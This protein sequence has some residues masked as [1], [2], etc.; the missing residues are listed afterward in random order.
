MAVETDEIGLTN[1]GLD[2]DSIP[3]HHQNLTTYQF[4]ITFSELSLKNFF[5]FYGRGGS[6]I[7]LCNI[8]N[9]KEIKKEMSLQ[10]FWKI[11]SG[12]TCWDRLQSPRPGNP[13][14]INTKRLMER[15]EK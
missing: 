6:S 11:K 4:G 7:F 10:C 1:K 2:K 8:E 5:F 14:R 13:N 12:G 3:D 15:A 9:I